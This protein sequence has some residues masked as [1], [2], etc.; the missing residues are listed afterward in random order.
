MKKLLKF[1]A[2]IPVLLLLSLNYLGAQTPTFPDITTLAPEDF[3]VSLMEPMYMLIVL[4]S[5]Y[6]SAFI[7]VVKTWS[8]FFRVLSFALVAALGFYLFGWASFSKLALNYFLSAGLYIT[9]LKNVFASPKA[10]A[11]G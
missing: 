9:F 6:V 2:L 11:A 10:A 8:P 3:F 1:V 4:A 7:P 5:G